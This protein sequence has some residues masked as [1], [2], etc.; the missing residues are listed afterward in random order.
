MKEIS[1]FT[2]KSLEDKLKQAADLLNKHK[3]KG[4]KAVHVGVISELIRFLKSEYP[5]LNREPLKIL[6]TDILAVRLTNPNGQLNMSGVGNKEESK[7]SRKRKTE[8]LILA[9]LELII[10]DGETEHEAIRFAAT[11]LKKKGESNV[12]KLLKSYRS[13]LFPFHIKELVQKLKLEG[14]K[15]FSG[16]QS[17]EIYLKRADQNIK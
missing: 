4:H 10:G 16:K 3:N 6:L 5:D 17:A 9:A 2:L 1:N 8:A 13:P 15:K 7:V 11:I 14:E 12:L